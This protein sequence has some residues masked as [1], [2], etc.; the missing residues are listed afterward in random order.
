MTYKEFCS[1]WIPMG[2]S[3]LGV[4]SGMLGSREDA[5]DVLQDLYIK[6]WQQR[7]TLDCVHNPPGYATRV[8]KNLCIDRLRARRQDEPLPPELEGSE[9]GYSDIENRESIRRIASAIGKLPETQRRILEMR[10]LQ[11]LSY[12]EISELT[13]K[14]QL[15]LRVLLSKARKTLRKYGES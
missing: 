2:E 4:A 15:A 3:L 8:L 5:E 9:P 6:L 7:D 1:T 14:N 12:E 10:T 11:G 13:G